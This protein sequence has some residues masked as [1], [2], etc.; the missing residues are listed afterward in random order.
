ML[1]EMMGMGVSVTV[2]KE[3]MVAPCQPSGFPS[4]WICVLLD[5]MTVT[6]WGT[7]RI[8]F[9]TNSE[10]M[11]AVSLVYFRSAGMLPSGFFPC[12]FSGEPGLETCG[13][14]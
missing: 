2:L 1:K 3:E 14:S 12:S 10:R 5:V 13:P 4:G 9:R 11:G 7:R 6:G 8:L